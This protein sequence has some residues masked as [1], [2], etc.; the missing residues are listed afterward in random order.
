MPHVPQPTRPIFLSA[1]RYVVGTWREGGR[2][3]QSRRERES[4]R[5]RVGER[6]IEREREKR[7]CE[8][9]Q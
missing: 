3:R 5:E 6:D 9:V 7:A 4:R 1:S 8:R 2:E